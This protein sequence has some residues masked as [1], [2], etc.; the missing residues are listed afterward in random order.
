MLPT[1]LT[2]RR[3][4][5]AQLQRGQA[6]R[7]STEA[8]RRGLDARIRAITT[9]IGKHTDTLKKIRGK[10]DAIKTTVNRWRSKK[11]AEDLVT[12]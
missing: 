7:A 1:Q 4:C 2:A 9:L 8:T 3:R 10:P 6:Q 5:R 12:E 11:I